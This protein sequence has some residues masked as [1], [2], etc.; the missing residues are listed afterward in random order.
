MVRFVVIIFAFISCLTLSA[1]PSL[2]TRQPVNPDAGL[3]GLQTHGQYHLTW[4]GI[5]VYDIKLWT[6]EPP[7]TFNL[8][9]VDQPIALDI[10]YRIDVDADDL[11][12]ETRDQWEE[13]SLLDDEAKQWLDDLQTM[14][15]NIKDGDRLVMHVDEQQHTRF[16]FNGALVG[17]I[18]NERFAPR[19]AAIWLAEGGEYPQMRRAL[20]GLKS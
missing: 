5:S 10:R 2:N 20:L 3:S 12:E 16:Y 8:Q 18:E 17:T 1:D 19:F 13:L 7:F 4:F 11:I 6:A 9:R 15:P 14:W